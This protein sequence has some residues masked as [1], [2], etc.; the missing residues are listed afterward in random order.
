M[1]FTWFSKNL[2][3]FLSI[4]IS[5]FIYRESEI[6]R[7]V[8][9]G[10]LLLQLRFQTFLRKNRCWMNKNSSNFIP[11]CVN[12]LGILL[13][14]VDNLDRPIIHTVWWNSF[15]RHYLFKVY[16]ELVDRNTIKPHDS[17]QA[18][19]FPSPVIFLFSLNPMCYTIRLGKLKS[20]RSNTFI[21]NP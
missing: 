6:S 3:M 7:R 1:I 15:F 4:N 12:T 14:I 11:C 5:E 21:P 19:F 10:A 17:T 2:K 8:P 18:K 9:G 16:K 20:K 13:D